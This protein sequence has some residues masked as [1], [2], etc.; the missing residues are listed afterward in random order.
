MNLAVFGWRVLAGGEWQ[1][2]YKYFGLSRTSR[3]KGEDV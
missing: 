2:I 3:A 1:A